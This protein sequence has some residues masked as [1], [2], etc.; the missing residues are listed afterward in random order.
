M[1]NVKAIISN[2]NKARIN[3]SSNSPI[4]TIN[5]YNCWDKGSCPMDGKCNEWN[6]IYQVEVTTSHSKQTCIGLC[7]TSFKSRYR[8]HACSFRNEPYKNSTD[9]NIYGAWKTRKLAIKLNGG[10]LDMWD[11]PSQLRIA[12]AFFKITVKHHV[13]LLSGSC[14]MIAS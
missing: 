8:G 10:L 9:L 12:T 1:S 4:Q 7:D 2:H 6:I 11:R 13:F 5:T 3:K 14:L